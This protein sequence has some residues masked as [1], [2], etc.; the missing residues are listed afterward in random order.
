MIRR[1]ILV[2]AVLAATASGLLLADTV[3]ARADETWRKEFRNTEEFQVKADWVSPTQR[4]SD[5]EAALTPEKTVVFKVNGAGK[6]MKWIMKGGPD[7]SKTPYG[8]LRYRATGINTTSPDYFLWLGDSKSKGIFNV[9]MNQI[10]ADGK[11]HEMSM[12]SD[13][14][15]PSDAIAFQVTASKSSNSATLE[16]DYLSFSAVPA[17]ADNWNKEW[18]ASGFL[19]AKYIAGG[20]YW[21]L[22]VA[23]PASK[24]ENIRPFDS[25]AVKGLHYWAK[26]GES[27]TGRI[28]WT[29]DAGKTGERD[30]LIR[31]RDGWHHYM[32]DLSNDAAWR[33]IITKIAVVFQPITIID[34]RPLAVLPP[35]FLE[36]VNL[37]PNADRSRPCPDAA[38]T[39]LGGW[40]RDT[41]NTWNIEMDTLLPGA[42]YKLAC[43]GAAALKVQSMKG[44]WRSFAIP[45][46]SSGSYVFKLPLDT[47]RTRFSFKNLQGTPILVM[48]TRGAIGYPDDPGIEAWQASWM[49]HP[50]Y[51]IVSGNRYFRRTF[52]LDSVPGSAAGW[53]TSNCRCNIYVNGIRAASWA[54]G[55][56]NRIDFLKGLKTGENVIAIDARN[57]SFRAWVMGE[58]YI[59][60]PGKPDVSIMTG[61]EWQCSKEPSDGW[62]L[63]GFN[64]RWVNAVTSGPGIWVRKTVDTSPY[65]YMGTREKISLSNIT[66]SNLKADRTA[67]VSISA[68]G[69]FSRPVTDKDRILLELS[70]DGKWYWRG[71][72]KVKSSAANPRRAEIKGVLP[73]PEIKTLSA[74][75][76]NLTLKMPKST[77]FEGS[78]EFS[79][80]LDIGRSTASRGFPQSS[81]RW[82]NSCPEIVVDGK[83]YLP[84]IFASGTMGENWKMAEGQVQAIADAASNGVR[85][86]RAHG[87]YFLDD[88][89]PEEGRMDFSKIDEMMR[90]LLAVDKDAKF[91]YAPVLN[92]PEWWRKK[93]PGDVIGYYGVGSLNDPKVKA[94]NP[95]LM[96]AQSPASARWR[97]DAGR[98]L[99]ALVNHMQKS[100]YASSIIG[101]LPSAL[102]TLEWI[103]P[104]S[105][106]AG[107]SDYS[108]ASVEG[109]R[110]YVRAKYPTL[111]ALRAAYNNP[112]ITHDA[113]TIP[114]PEKL[115][116]R[117]IGNLRDPRL[118][119]NSIDYWE[120][121]NGINAEALTSFCKIVKEESNG[122]LLSGSYFG[123]LLHFSSSALLMQRAGHL[124]LDKVTESPYVD[125]LC[126]PADYTFRIASCP[127]ATM[128]P[129]D[130]LRLHNKLWI[131]EDDLRGYIARAR[132][133]ATP[134]YNHG[135]TDTVADAMTLF[136]KQFALSRAQGYGFWRLDLYA[137]FFTNPEMNSALLGRWIKAETALRR[138]DAL[139]MPAEVAFVVDGPGYAYDGVGGV[140]PVS[141]RQQLKTFNCIGVPRDVIQMK[142]FINTKLPPYKLYIFLNTFA[143]DAQTRLKIH[144]KLANDRATAVW[145]YADGFYN[146]TPGVSP[147]AANIQKLTGIKPGVT[148]S[149]SRQNIAINA[150]GE[151]LSWQMPSQTSPTFF[152]E[153]TS[154]RPL[155]AGEGGKVGAAWKDMGGWTSIYISNPYL[156]L[157]ALRYLCKRAG[158][159]M[160]FAGDD[161]VYIGKGFFATNA[162]SSGEKK[163][164]FPEKVDIAD[165]ESGKVLAT[166]VAQFT[167]TAAS[168][169]AYMYAV[170]RNKK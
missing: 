93:Y 8:T 11:W 103:Y 74:G 17:K 161:P 4:A 32:F 75:K 124:F 96:N 139:P 37:L 157:P 145:L 59:S 56:P 41:G 63:P 168:G 91:L 163:I 106:G 25:A 31:N 66:V 46:D 35:S 149:R 123:Y 77:F 92:M 153:D 156:P 38:G 79:R 27:V 137:D 141:M 117:E 133:F 48:L 111:D 83:P 152:V 120:Y 54:P 127:A 67:P 140:G 44:E 143:V 68:M 164:I 19:Q 69:E 121:R 104:P 40:R 21:D 110:Q 102:V 42:T 166:G 100:D 64:G 22:R 118:A 132:Y 58:F 30:F 86:F 47:L 61:D 76:Y 85:L 84:Y 88:T 170:T 16:V 53:F 115:Y 20:G 57:T 169:E 105:S 43:P 101:V 113:V 130:T 14:R 24:L 95:G 128:S 138:K 82:S 55:G 72:L 15:L 99:K 142:D 2:L 18:K 39:L 160:Y 78:S 146:G 36:E 65:R 90:V 98:Y 151:Q 10:V 135:K 155:G 165:Y 5:Y 7:L 50:E 29:N 134:E 6:A 12:A 45:R 109:F 125:I 89:W 71:R 70:K 116:A 60:Y 62:M 148:V 3:C 13:K 34:G 23:R 167:F 87:S 49:W 158:V 154:A 159:H 136:R 131:Q 150:G 80:T 9:P 129:A 94:A 51:P 112:A 147:D 122:R 144:E 1:H 108:K 33:G 26:S 97:E 162:T 81:V 73:L 119:Q 126:A 28:Q 52:R 107:N 114:A